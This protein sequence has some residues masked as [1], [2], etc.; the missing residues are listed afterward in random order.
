MDL[1]FLNGGSTVCAFG[2]RFLKNKHQSL[3]IAFYDEQVY[4]F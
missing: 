1:F 3:P 4:Y 2:S